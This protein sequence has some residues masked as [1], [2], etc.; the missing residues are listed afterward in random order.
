MAS[1]YT[2][3]CPVNVS[4]GCVGYRNAHWGRNLLILT[5]YQSESLSIFLCSKHKY[6][7]DFKSQGVILYRKYVLSNLSALSALSWNVVRLGLEQ[8]GLEVIQELEFPLIIN[9]QNKNEI[10]QIILKILDY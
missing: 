1:T 2:S 6:A 5:M 4:Q 10:T 9:A 3:W 7:S 8:L